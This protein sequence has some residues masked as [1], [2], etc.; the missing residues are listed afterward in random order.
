[1]WV[2]KKRYVH[3][4]TL[5]FNFQPKMLDEKRPSETSSEASANSGDSKDSK[6][7]TSVWAK[8]ALERAA[9]SAPRSPMAK[10]EAREARVA[11]YYPSSARDGLPR[12]PS[13]ASAA[14]PPAMSVGWVLGARSRNNSLIGA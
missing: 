2:R 9:A 8:K 10:R 6:T 7:N 11:R 13:P 14:R 3:V 1:M 5:I 12:E 4:H